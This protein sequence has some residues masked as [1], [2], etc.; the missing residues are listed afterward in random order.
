MKKPDNQND[1]DLRTDG[2][3]KDAD[4]GGRDVLQNVSTI[5]RKYGLKITAILAFMGFSEKMMLNKPATP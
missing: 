4:G 1:I 3:G 2:G 5:C